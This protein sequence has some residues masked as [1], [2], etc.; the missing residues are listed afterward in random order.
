MAVMDRAL[1]E[2]QV[3][4]LI[5]SSKHPRPQFYSATEAEELANEGLKIIDWASTVSANEEPDLVIAAA[6]TEPN[7]EALA[8]VSLLNQAFPQL[9]I[10]FINVVDILKLRHPSVDP[11]GLSDEVFDT[12]F[13]KDKPILFAFHGYEAHDP[14]YFLLTTQS[15]IDGP[16]LSRKW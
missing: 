10:R 4:N 15:P 5:I 7:L 9:K 14:G 16:W 3:I 11:R 12:F 13:T 8:A 6:G 2:E 1:Q